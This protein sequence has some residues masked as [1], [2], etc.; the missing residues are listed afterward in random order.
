[1]TISEII[2]LCFLTQKIE[3][4]DSLGYLY[5]GSIETLLCD[6]YDDWTIAHFSACE[7]GTLSVALACAFSNLDLWQKGIKGTLIA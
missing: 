2:P 4:C 5:S 1:M 6:G 3:L 7:D